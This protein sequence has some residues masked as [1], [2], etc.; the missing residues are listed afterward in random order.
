M[1]VGFSGLARHWLKGPQS[2]RGYGIVGRISSPPSRHK[3]PCELAVTLAVHL[4]N[5]Q[6][7]RS[8]FSEFTNFGLV[9]TSAISIFRA[10]Q[11]AAGA[12]KGP[13]RFILQPPIG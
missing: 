4:S 9:S 11:G 7:R 6:L 10:P 2:E 1:G 3:I 13:Q 12:L 8:F 5:R